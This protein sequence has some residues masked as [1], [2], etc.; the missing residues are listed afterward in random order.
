MF[1]RFYLLKIKLL[2]IK[3]QIW[4][5]FVV[6]ASISLERLHDVIQVVM[7]WQDSHLHE[8]T[9]NEQRYTE[10]PEYEEDG[11]CCAEFRLGQLIKRKRT[12]FYYVYDFGD[13]WEHELV[14]EE[15]RFDVSTL[16]NEV[17]CLD[18]KRACPP[19]DVGGIGGFE[20][21]CQILKNPIHE[22]Y[23]EY[24]HWTGGYDRENFDQNHVNLELLKYMRW[25]RDRALG[26]EME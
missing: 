23:D 3:P 20:R 24:M 17:E 25:S 9:I 15:T 5:K 11:L 22:E 13:F 16:R 19:E 26:W 6:P 21:M 7:G 4:R 1:D 8:F 12:K 10:Y 2:H 18:G 14:V